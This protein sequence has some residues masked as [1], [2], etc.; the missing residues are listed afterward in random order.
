[1]HCLQ[2][3]VQKSNFFI[4][5]FDLKCGFKVKHSFTPHFKFIK[6]MLLK[7]KLLVHFSFRET[8][9]HLVRLQFAIQ[10]YQHRHLYNYVYLFVYRRVHFEHPNRWR[11]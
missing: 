3:F 2:P 5:Y 10:V 4:T 6:K 11:Y 1:M 7:I 8:I 9:T